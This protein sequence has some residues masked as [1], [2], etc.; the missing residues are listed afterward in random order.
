MNAD[1]VW[2][3]VRP[4]IALYACNRAYTAASILIGTSLVTDFLAIWVPYSELCT[5][6]RYFS[7]LPATGQDKSSYF[8]NLSTVAEE[9]AERLTYGWR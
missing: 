6:R 3:I 4:V 5:K 7:V 1:A 8:L 2:A 9:V